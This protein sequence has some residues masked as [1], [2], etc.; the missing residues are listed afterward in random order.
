MI[1]S[2]QLCLNNWPVAFLLKTL[3]QSYTCLTHD[4]GCVI[5]QTRHRHLVAHTH[6][7]AYLSLTH[8]SLHQTVPL[9]HV[10]VIQIA[11][12]MALMVAVSEA[13]SVTVF[14]WMTTVNKCRHVTGCYWQCVWCHCNYTLLNCTTWYRQPNMYTRTAIVTNTMG[15]VLYPHGHTPGRRAVRYT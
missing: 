11:H 2:T 6:T 3:P 12:S 10:Y 4:S 13:T 7:P 1:P 15:V 8:P 9:L 14:G 5:S